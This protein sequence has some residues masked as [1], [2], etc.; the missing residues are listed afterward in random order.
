MTR[1]AID[2]ALDIMRPRNEPRLDLLEAMPSAN[3]PL[4]EHRTASVIVAAIK[5]ASLTRHEMGEI[6]GAIT[7]AICRTALGKHTGYPELEE[8]AHDLSQCCEEYAEA[9]DKIEERLSRT[10][11]EE[12]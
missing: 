1:T 11:P 10:Y 12:V 6:L 8:T 4:A 3:H 5:T 9:Q 7:E 2:D